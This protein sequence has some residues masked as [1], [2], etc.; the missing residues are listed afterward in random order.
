[1]DYTTQPNNTN[2]SNSTNQSNKTKIILIIIF[3]VILF[4]S[5]VA[6]IIY[7]KKKN[8]EKINKNNNEKKT[9]SSKNKNTL[10][11]D[12][13]INIAINNNV[14]KLKTEYM[15]SEKNNIK[16][17]GCFNTNK[18]FKIPKIISNKRVSLI[19][20]IN[21]KDN[22]KDDHVKLINYT[23]NNNNNSNN[24]SSIN[25]KPSG[26]FC[27]FIYLFLKNILFFFNN[28]NVLM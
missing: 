26:I 11:R 27:L 20:K 24:S 4:S 12:K 2:Q 17:L 23:N 14:S 28:N 7:Y 6:S 8:N 3:V 22:T 19:N 16:K 5:S 1:M 10:E 25:E 18:S 13:S 9:T 21:Y 15:F